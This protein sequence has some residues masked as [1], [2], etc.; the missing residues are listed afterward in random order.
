MAMGRQLL[1][2]PCALCFGHL[3]TWESYVPWGGD[4]WF[5]EMLPLLCGLPDPARGMGT[6]ISCLP[7][8]LWGGWHRSNVSHEI[9]LAKGSGWCCSGCHCASWELTP[10]SVPQR[11]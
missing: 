5:Q 1:A 6:S 11:R 3:V 4:A 10:I 2:G 7:F 8:W 9:S